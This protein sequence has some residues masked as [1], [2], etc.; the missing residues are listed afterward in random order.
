[1]AEVVHCV[2]KGGKPENSGRTYY[3][4][5]SC[6]HYKFVTDKL[7]DASMPGSVEYLVDEVSCPLQLLPALVMHATAQGQCT[8]ILLWG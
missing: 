3:S 4:C 8:D 6:R 7:L 5:K 2:V 1:M